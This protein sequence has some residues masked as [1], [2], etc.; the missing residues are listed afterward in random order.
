MSSYDVHS[1]KIRI[2]LVIVCSSFNILRC[3]MLS[4]FIPLS[5]V[6]RRTLK[7]SLVWATITALASS[8]VWV[9]DVK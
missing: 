4:V 1:R 2:A 9:V 8:L 5:L 6:L 3:L 7:L